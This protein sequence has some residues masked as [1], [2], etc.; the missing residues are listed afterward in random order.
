VEDGRTPRERFGADLTRTVDRLRTLGLARLEAS[1]APEPTRA[2]A[3][4]EVAQRLADESADLEGRPRRQLPTL[5][6]HAVG[7]QLAVT[8]HDLLAAA[9]DR[10]ISVVRSDPDSADGHAPDV[11]AQLDAL[12]T[13]AADLLLDLRRRL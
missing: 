8:G 6:A 2:D 13:E 10:E 3:A 7:D 1:F 4:H 9:G 5:G 12:L 11:R